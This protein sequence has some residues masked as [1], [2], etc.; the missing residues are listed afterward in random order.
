LIGWAALITAL[1]TI[2]IAIFTLTLKRATDKLWDASERQ[3]K[4]LADTSAIQSGDMQASIAAARQS[5]DAA[6]KAAAHVP[7]TERAYLFLE[8]DISSNFET[9]FPEKPEG[10]FIRPHV[11]FGFRNHGRTPAIIQELQATA[12]YWP[13]SAGAPPISLAVPLTIQPGLVVSSEPITGYRV[14]FSLTKGQFDNAYF[15]RQGY[16]MFWGKI[17]YLDVF[18]VRHETGWCRANQRDGRGW[19]FGGDETLNYYT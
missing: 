1:A 4:L 5:A 16:I 18:Q 17:I 19:S 8:L 6:T 11:Q 12:K 13:K 14:T 7:Q 3:L 2:A 9:I 10:P 15:G